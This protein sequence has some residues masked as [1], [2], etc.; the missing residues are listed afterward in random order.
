MDITDANIYDTIDVPIPKT[1]NEQV[2]TISIYSHL[3]A[4]IIL[5][6]SFTFA[7]ILSSNDITWV[8]LRFVKNIGWLE[9]GA[10]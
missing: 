5:D 4:R 2:T 3:G 7:F 1:T 9:S 10:S 8:Y 6:E